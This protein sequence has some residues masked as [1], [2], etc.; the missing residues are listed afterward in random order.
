MNPVSGG[1]TGR[2]TPSLSERYREFL[3]QRIEEYKEQLPRHELLTLGD[4]ALE[5]LRTVESGQLSLTEVVLRDY[6]DDL[7]RRDLRLPSYRSWR[8]RFVKLRNAQRQ[9]THWGLDSDQPLIQHVTRMETETAVVIGT[10]AAPYGFLMAAHDARVIIIDRDIGTVETSEHVAAKEWLDGQVETL[11]V[12]LE[13]CPGGTL[14]N[15]L[16]SV[17]RFDGSCVGLVLFD[18][19]A[20]AQLPATRRIELLEALKDMTVVGGTHLMAPACSS[21]GSVTLSSDALRGVYGDWIA[22]RPAHRAR[23]TWFVATRPCDSP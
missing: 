22:D 20:L 1:K 12:D 18:S 13:Y 3:A 7:I 11:V 2:R 17:P 23:Q 9:A 16:A 10:A 19:R 21:G 4:A 15:L 5:K 8:N 6:V 14:F